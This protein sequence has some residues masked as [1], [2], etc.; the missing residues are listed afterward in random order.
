MNSGCRSSSSRFYAVPLPTT[1]CEGACRQEPAN[2]TNRLLFLLDGYPVASSQSQ[3]ITR[4]STITK[5]W[6]E[7]QINHTTLTQI[8]SSI[9]QRTNHNNVLIYSSKWIVFNSS[10]YT[11]LFQYKISAK[12]NDSSGFRLSLTYACMWSQE[13]VSDINILQSK[14]TQSNQKFNDLMIN[15]KV[16]SQVHLH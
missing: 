1:G 15:F 12:L 9:S 16:G 3:S 5:N 10:A 8:Q 2:R 6:Q 11:K 13:V 4:D 14:S 7:K